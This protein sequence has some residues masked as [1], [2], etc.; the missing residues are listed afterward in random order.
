MK[1]DNSLFYPF[2]SNALPLDLHGEVEPNGE[3]LMIQTEHP[4]IQ[5]Y[6]PS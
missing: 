5:V 2:L 4:M 1:F 3:L 6:A